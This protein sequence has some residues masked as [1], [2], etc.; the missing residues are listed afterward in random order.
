MSTEF[1]STITTVQLG[2]LWGVMQIVD[3][4]TKKNVIGFT[5]DKNT[6][7]I[8]AKKFAEEHRLEYKENALKF[9]RPVI[10]ICKAKNAEVYWITTLYDAY[11]TRYKLGLDDRSRAVG[12]AQRLARE[13]NLSY[14]SLPDGYSFK[15]TGGVFI[16]EESH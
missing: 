7:E 14:V 5:S 6:V 4:Q 1:R 2:G 16:K 8:A 15:E 13:K 3:E 12:K 9:D 11:A 10:A